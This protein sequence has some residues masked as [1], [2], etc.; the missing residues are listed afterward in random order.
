VQINTVV[1]AVMIRYN[2]LIRDIGRSQ[3]RLEADR[4]VD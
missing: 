4:S 2:T 3:Q 1:G